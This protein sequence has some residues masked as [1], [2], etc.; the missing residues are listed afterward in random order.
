MIEV[1][2]LHDYFTCRKWSERVF[3]PDAA[4]YRKGMRELRTRKPRPRKHRRSA[5]LP[6]EPSE[7][8]D[9]AIECF[10]HGVAH[11]ICELGSR[12]GLAEA[13]TLIE[14]LA[15]KDP[16]DFRSTE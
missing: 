8:S 16:N 4:G 11:L 15:A 14:V 5:P 1:P 9:Q 13:R 2:R 7:L 10:T 6:L 12:D 3:D